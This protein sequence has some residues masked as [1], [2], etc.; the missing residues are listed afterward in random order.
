[1]V[2]LA[3]ALCWVST[4][5]AVSFAV[6]VTHSPWCLWAMLLPACIE[7]KHSGKQK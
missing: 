5:G 3:V 7:V 1:M 4:A 6:F 2:Y